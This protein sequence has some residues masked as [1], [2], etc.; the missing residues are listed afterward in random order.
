MTMR[1][2]RTILLCLCTLLLTPLAFAQNAPAASAPADAATAVA[3]A[4]T[5]TIGVKVAPPFVIRDG[6]HYRGLAIDLWEEVAADHGWKFQYKSYDL[7]GLL[8]A[9][10]RHQVDVGLGAITAT[11]QREQRMDFAHPITSSGLG[12]A[13]RN[14]SGS[15]W[16]AVAQALVSPAF[17]SVIGTLIVLLLAVGLLVWSLEHKHNPEQ[18]GGTRAQGIFSGFWWAMVTMTT[19]GYG[20]TAPRTVPGRLLGMVWMLAALMVV[21]FFTASITSAL[22]VGQLS[23]RIRTADDLSHVRVASI[24]GSTSG[25]WLQRNQDSFVHADS[26]DDALERLA[27]GKV[28]AVVYDAP[29]LRWQINQQ[30]SGLRV[31][32]L[33]LER[34]DYAFALPDNSPLREQIDTSLLQRIN[35]PDWNQR[36]KKYFGPDRP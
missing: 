7:E 15:G 8:N 19:V 27:A 36:L 14:Q 4:R 3:P 10:Q 2:P 26:L 5:L 18:F 1:T 21:S 23:N 20:D 29:L 16:L 30:F 9:V 35:A 28:D 25:Q 17:L 24:A 6:D 11:A 22:T 13:V 33:R 31:L 32:P 12:I 34:Q